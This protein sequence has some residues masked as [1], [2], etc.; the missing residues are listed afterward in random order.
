MKEEHTVK[1]SKELLTQPTEVFSVRCK[2]SERV[3]NAFFVCGSISIEE[4]GC[5]A[6]VQW[7]MRSTRQE[8]ILRVVS[9]CCDWVVVLALG[10]D[11]W[12]HGEKWHVAVGMHTSREVRFLASL[13]QTRTV[14]ITTWDINPRLVKMIM[15]QREKPRQRCET[16]KCPS[17]LICRSVFGI[18][19]WSIECSH[20]FAL[21]GEFFK[22]L[23]A[24]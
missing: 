22:I 24:S 6:K 20:P 9:R 3:A 12:P 21:S 19:A 15:Q 11:L 4:T 23:L 5:S 8:N 18:L 14:L 17:Q 16:I 2:C 10:L 13:L 7:A 1:R